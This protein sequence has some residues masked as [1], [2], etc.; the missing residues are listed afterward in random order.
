MDDL[1]KQ[2]ASLPPEKRELF[3]LMLQEQGVDLAKIAILPQPR[4]RNR[5]PLSYSQQRLWF[6]DQL[7]PGSA[8]YNIAPAIR[9]RGALNVSALEM[10][11]REL[12]RRHEALRT[13]FEKDGG[14]PV[15]VIHEE[16]D[17]NITLTE[18]TEI[19]P[20]QI[21]A[22]IRQHAVAEAARPFNLQTGPLL[23]ASLL[24]FSD[25][26]HL[27]LI[28]MHH[29]VSDNWSTGLLVHE[30]I[31]LYEAF[32]RNQPSPLPEI[33]AQYA[34]FAVWQRKWLRGKTLE[35]QVKFWREHLE[36]APPALEM[37]LDF[38]RPAYQT[39]N[40]DSLAFS[41]SK[42]E[43]ARLHELGRRYDATLFMTLLASFYV[44][45]Y[46]Y[47]GQTDICVGTPIANRNRAETEALIGF[48]VNTLALRA[49]LSGNPAFAALLRQI[50]DITLGAYA[51]QDL[52]F[53]TLVEELHPER[54]MSRSP[55]FQCMFVL[56]NAPVE[57]LLMSGLELSLVEIENKT[58]KFDLIFNALESENG[59][60]FK[61]EFNTDL[62][63][64]ETIRRMIGHYTTIL[65][66]VIRNPEQPIADM[67]LL[68]PDEAR[69]LLEWSQPPARIRSGKN[70][71]ELFR[72]GLAD[73]ADT[74][75]IRVM[76]EM[77]TYRQL[78]ELSDR[79][80]AHLMASGLTQ[81]QIAGVCAGRS[82]QLMIGLWAVLKAGGVYLPLDPSYPT[83]RL[84][85]MFNDSGASLLVTEQKLAHLLNGDHLQTVL[86]DR[87]FIDALPVPGRFT[88]P[89]IAGDQT[90][91]IIYTSGS[92]G[93]PKGVE[94][95]HAAIA[96]HC[97]DMQ[98]HYE[99]T[100]QDRVLQ[101][102][103]L[104]FDASIEQILPPLIT[105]ATVIMREDEL[106]ETGRFHEML[107]RHDLTVINLPTAYWAQL[108]RE[109]VQQPELADGHRVRLVIIGGDT[110]NPDALKLWQQTAMN[111]IRLLNAYGPTETTI[112][113]T[114]FE[115]KPDFS[116]QYRI[117]RV[118]IGRPRANREVY[119]VDALNYPTPPGVPGELLIGGN[120]LAKGYLNR[121]ELT[122]EKFISNLLA[123]GD[124]NPNACPEQSRRDKSQI[125]NSACHPAIAG[126]SLGR[127]DSEDERLKIKDQKQTEDGNKI[128]RQ[129]Y[130]GTAEGSC[131]AVAAL[132]PPDRLYRTGDLARFLP[133]GNIDFMGR[134]DQQVKIRGF[135][136][137]LGEIETLL[138]K[139][140]AIRNVVVAARGEK[141]GEKRLVAYYEQHADVDSA[142]LRNF[143]KTQL[144]D[145]MIPAIFMHLPQLP[146]D[147]SG[148]I[149]RR[150]LPEPSG[151][152]LQLRTAYVAPRTPTE[153]KLAGI[154]GEVLNLNKVGVQDNF[155]ELGGHSMMATQ[156]VS[157]IRDAFGVEVSLRAL[158]EHPTVEGIATAITEVE[159]RDRQSDNIEQFLDELEG[160]SEEEVQRLL[161]EN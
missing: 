137:E 107:R 86:L 59:V 21:D 40:G 117:G 102:A 42:E 128:N 156:V 124:K 158:F 78:D 63:R 70:I 103:A 14:Q 129:A 160:L 89:A 127:E 118:P 43:L 138:H 66:S 101:F 108:A 69:L 145:Y 142:E 149:N 84:Q 150:A 50:K 151:E 92:T 157:R 146:L 87:G 44:L 79:L 105:G 85:Y 159:A 139:H 123:A 64:P 112:T 116:E 152:D 25:L 120:A 148:K 36:G 33:T 135:R 55:F 2:I 17:F 76:D 9:I 16:S 46:R 95:S 121:P 161:D 75:A 91:Y 7:E 147:P 54:N 111:N 11:F 90:A 132:L 122:E 19:A 73:H 88:F 140:Q 6:L 49:G 1:Y 80:A 13:T 67:A 39:N 31:R 12:I 65:K 20:A 3:E 134:V 131:H 23:R 61:V 74:V 26:D 29:I 143:L 154:V 153:E 48:F 10:S 53:E 83:E 27:L 94:I 106:W 56:N 155:F 114:T 8:L 24:R 113:A 110:L 72:A 47:S 109:W 115:I 41:L 15:Q 119:I 130:P 144:P 58:S 62:Y 60:S 38:Q 125:S 126:P 4:N 37:P 81:G 82:V 133:D 71:I 22:E 51:H 97:L 96:D 5:F 93:Q 104:N 136:I 28:T 34:D 141:S 30:V 98:A 68:S 99:L 45:L 32:S 57:K 77:L 18:L 52:P 100:T 35:N